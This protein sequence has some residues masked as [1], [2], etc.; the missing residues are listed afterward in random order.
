MPPSFLLE[1]CYPNKVIAGI[2][3]V[4]SGAIA[5]PVV[6][7]AAILDRKYDFA[8]YVDDSKNLSA[9]RR[10]KSYE[11]LISKVTYSIGIASRAEI[12]QLNIRNA[13]MLACKRAVE[14]L[15]F[16]PEVCLVDGNMKF[17]D[18]RYVS[19][20]KGDQI[21]YSVAAA[22]II[23]KVFRDYLMTLLSVSFQAYNWGQNKGYGTKEHIAFLKNLGSSKHHRRSFIKKMI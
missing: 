4:G 19:I 17:K 5:G 15:D 16:I 11:F 13:T 22:S 14:N 1:D 10:D 23:A 2:D 6:A 20:I 9:K 8:G 12:D 7:C 21:S 18:S 3:E